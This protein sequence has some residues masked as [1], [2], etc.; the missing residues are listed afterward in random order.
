MNKCM[1]C[2]GENLVSTLSEF[3]SMECEQ[4]PDTEYTASITIT[5]QE[6]NA[7][8]VEHANRLISEMLDL[9]ADNDL[10]LPLSGVEWV[11]S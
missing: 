11:I 1:N 4:A 6:F 2:L 7:K 9:M 5:I 8:N 10:E 3:C